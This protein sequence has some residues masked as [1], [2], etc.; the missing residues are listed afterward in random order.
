MTRY[1][2]LDVVEGPRPSQTYDLTGESTL[3]GRDP[4]CAVVVDDPEVSRRH[5]RILQRGGAWLIEDLESTNGTFVNGERVVTSQPLTDGDRIRLSNAILLTFRAAA[6]EEAGT[7]HHDEDDQ[8]EVAH[9]RDAPHAHPPSDATAASRE[10]VSVTSRGQTGAVKPG[11]R[12]QGEPR[13]T[14]IWM[15]AAFIAL[16]TIA[17]IALLLI[18]QLVDGL[19]PILTG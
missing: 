4:R 3:V 15:A 11:R 14:W 19:P 12:Q 17:V 10:R 8:A 5:A 9:S 16:A 6:E 18:L 1:P 7:G 13:L 2:Q